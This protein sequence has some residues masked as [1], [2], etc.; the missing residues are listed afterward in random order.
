[1]REVFLKISIILTFCGGIISVAYAVEKTNYE[2]IYSSIN[3]ESL[4]HTLEDTVIDLERVN[5]L[6][7][8]SK[9]HRI[10]KAFSLEYLS[11]S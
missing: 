9:I 2:D 4:E 5:P 7:I 1:M 10:N 6:M 3:L 8:K 11:R